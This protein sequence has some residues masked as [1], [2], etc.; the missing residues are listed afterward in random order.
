MHSKQQQ[1]QQNEMKRIQRIYQS[2]SNVMRSICRSVRMSISFYIRDSTMGDL[3]FISLKF[4][5]L[6]IV[7]IT[8]IT[9]DDIRFRT[10][11][12]IQSMFVSPSVYLVDFKL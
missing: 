5:L 7:F 10:F 1:L 12:V 8:H 6:I 3:L 11:Y 2:S 4:Y 9:L